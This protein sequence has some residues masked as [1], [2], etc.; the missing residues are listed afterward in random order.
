MGACPSPSWTRRR[1]LLASTKHW[2]SSRRCSTRSAETFSR[3]SRRTFSRPNSAECA[4]ESAD[5]HYTC[6]S[7]ADVWLSLT[8]RRLHGRVRPLDEREGSKKR[9]R[10]EPKPKPASS[11]T[12]SATISIL[13]NKWYTVADC[14]LFRMLCKLKC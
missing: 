2:L 5:A 10:T 3:G 8:D 12:R 11:S 7:A 14:G 6:A 1:F 13:L 9:R 4:A